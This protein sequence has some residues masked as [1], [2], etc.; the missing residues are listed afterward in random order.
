MI[1]LDIDTRERRTMSKPRSLTVNDDVFNRFNALKV[2]LA[3]S[4]ENRIPKII[5]IVS[6]LVTLGETHYDE[7]T[8]LMKEPENES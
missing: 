8:E 2:R 5:D 7:L 3:I 1:P 6:A 4:N